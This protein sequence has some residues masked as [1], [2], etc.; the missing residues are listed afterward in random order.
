MRFHFRIIPSPKTSRPKSHPGTPASATLKVT[1]PIEV[2]SIRRLGP[3][4]LK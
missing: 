4:T 3:L 1:R 2:K